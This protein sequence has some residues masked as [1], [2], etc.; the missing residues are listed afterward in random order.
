M[1]PELAKFFLSLS[2]SVC[3]AELLLFLIVG[4]IVGGI[5]LVVVLLVVLCFLCQYIR[6]QHR[7]GKISESPLTSPLPSST[8]CVC[9]C[10]AITR[11]G[12]DSTG[13]ATDYNLKLV[14]C[15]PTDS[16]TSFLHLIRFES[17]N[18]GLLPNKGT[19]SPNPSQRVDSTT[20]PPQITSPR[21][22]SPLLNSQHYYNSLRK[23][24]L[25]TLP[26]GRHSEEGS[27][28]RVV[29]VQIHSNLQSTSAKSIVSLTSL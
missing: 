11:R 17:F 26:V 23:Y 13:V 7:G 8:W 12:S 1:I 21:L 27:K 28:G 5:L 16:F 15:Y 25:D 10:I 19:T 2:L 3:L 4:G 18:G 29:E 20:P 24:Q 6:R 14:V 22:T 9:L